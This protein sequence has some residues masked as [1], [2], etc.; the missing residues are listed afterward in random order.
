[1]V[2]DTNN[3]DFSEEFLNFLA[4]ANTDIYADALGFSAQF[5]IH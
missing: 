3:L 2:L 4:Q 5:R 1:M